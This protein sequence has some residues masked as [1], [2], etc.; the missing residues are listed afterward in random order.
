M[1]ARRMKPKQLRKAGFV[2]V[3]NGTIVIGFNPFRVLDAKSVMNLLLKLGEG[4]ALVSSYS[5]VGVFF[6]TVYLRCLVFA[7][8]GERI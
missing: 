5:S 1:V 3:A 7:G 6:E 8:L 2:K 4:R